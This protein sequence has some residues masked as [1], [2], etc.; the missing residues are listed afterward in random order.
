[1][2]IPED[3][4]IPKTSSGFDQNA[5][6]RVK[7]AQADDAAVNFDFWA[8]SGKTQAE[9]EARVVLRLFAKLW[10]VRNL[11]VE[12]YKFVKARGNIPA[13]TEAV[14]DCLRRAEGSDYW[15]WH[16]GSSLFFWRFPDECGWRKD[17]RDGVRFWHLTD[18]SK[19]MNFQNI[20]TETREDELQLRSKLFT[21]MFRWY[22]DGTNILTLSYLPFQS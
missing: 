11:R 15:T 8:I 1:M 9:V 3:L 6:Q 2:S 13:D 4:K 10:W 16:R 18:P 12:A 19:G 5:Q 7:A 20:P 22:M 21:I 14:E 17:T